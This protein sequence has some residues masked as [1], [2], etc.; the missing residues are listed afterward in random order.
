MRVG[1]SGL[2]GLSQAES[3]RFREGRRRPERGRGMRRV[4]GT[5][6]RAVAF[7]MRVDLARD[8]TPRH[9]TRLSFE[10]RDTRSRTCGRHALSCQ[11]R[12]RWGGDSRRTAVYHGSE[13]PTFPGISGVIAGQAGRRRILKTAR[14][15][16]LK[17]SNPL[18]SAHA[19]KPRRRGARIREEPVTGYRPSGAQRRRRDARSLSDGSL[20]LRRCRRRAQRGPAIGGGARI[21]EEPG[22]AR[23]PSGAQRRPHHVRSHTRRVPRPPLPPPTARSAVTRGAR[24]RW[25]SASTRPAPPRHVGPRHRWSERVV[26]SAFLLTL[27]PSADPR[28]LRSAGG[29]SP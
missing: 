13:Y 15:Q 20:A 28:R 29:A 27:A 3:V 14:W 24:S 26:E 8:V 16:H 21:R 5:R 1:R 22:T 6:A 25:R 10:A 4:P 9:P 17:G 19:A 12:A 7:A 2:A 11:I 18:P 23:D